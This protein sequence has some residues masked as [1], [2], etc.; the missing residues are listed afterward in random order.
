MLFLKMLEISAI[1]GIIYVLSEV[2]SANLQ[3]NKLMDE[4]P[5][6]VFQDNDIS[7]E[8]KE[9]ILTAVYDSM[10]YNLELNMR[11]NMDKLN[12]L[13]EIRGKRNANE[14]MMNSKQEKLYNMN[15]KTL[16]NLLDQ[17]KVLSYPTGRLQPNIMPPNHRSDYGGGYD[18]E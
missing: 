12:L 2:L 16:N 10:K 8:R 3:P 5:E 14:L 18:D 9:S 6:A 7:P 15:D 1:Y 13:S 4:I 17:R 11:N